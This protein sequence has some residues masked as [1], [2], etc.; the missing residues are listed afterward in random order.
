MKLLNLVRCGLLAAGVVCI[1]PAAAMDNNQTIEGQCAQKTGGGWEGAGFWANWAYGTCAAMGGDFFLGAAQEIG[2]IYDDEFGDVT[3]YKNPQNQKEYYVQ[4][5]KAGQF[6]LGLG[7][8]FMLVPH[9]PA[10]KLFLPKFLV[11]PQPGPT[12]NLAD[13]QAKQQAKLMQSGIKAGIVPK[14]P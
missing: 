10:G 2:K 13:L 11:N 9:P 8:Q 5:T 6:R 4:K 3:F 12:L 14:K 7:N 1:G